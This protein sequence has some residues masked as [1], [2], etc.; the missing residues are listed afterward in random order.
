MS[1]NTSSQKK[2]PS[3]VLVSL[4]SLIALRFLAGKN[5]IKARKK[6]SS[7]TAGNYASPIRGRGMDF[8]EVRLYQPGD[9]IRSIDWRV[10]ARTGKAHTKL[11]TEERERPVYFVVDTGA[12]MQ[13]G[14]RVAFKS[15]IAAKLAGLLAWSALSH[16]DRI[17][18]ILFSGKEHEEIKP[19]NTKR[20]ILTFFKKLVEW[21]QRNLSSDKLSEVSDFYDVAVRLKRVAR[22]GSV[23]YLISDFNQIDEKAEMYFSLI[24]KHCELIMIN[25]FDPLEKHSPPPGNYMLTDGSVFEKLSITNKRVSQEFEQVFSKKEMK[26]KQFCLQR[27]IRYLSVCTT[28]D[29]QKMIKL[30][31][32]QG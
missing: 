24:A 22:P 21:N 5:T 28:D 16:G 3:N 1:P 9:D 7:I 19:N 2:F 6:T 8:S 4:E 27:G 32:S 26:L 30:N 29:L 31:F 11:F 23:V 14:T 15:V 17:G 10:T 25:V 12:S 20:G 13:F 18:G